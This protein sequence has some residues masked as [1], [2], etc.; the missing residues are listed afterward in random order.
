[1]QQAYP[2]EQ[3]HRIAYTKLTERD[4]GAK[5]AATSGPAGV[6][7][8]SGALA[9]KTLRI[10]TDKPRAGARCDSSN[11]ACRKART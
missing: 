9:G 8:A 6:T 10:V 3:M 11:G 1:V 4:I 7:P 2:K 5:L